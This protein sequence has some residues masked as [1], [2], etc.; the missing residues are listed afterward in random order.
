MKKF[1]EKEL[2]QLYKEAK[3]KEIPDLWK[4]IEEN[5]ASKAPETEAAPVKEKQGSHRRWLTGLAAAAAVALLAI[6]AWQMQQG[7]RKDLNESAQEAPAAEAN[8]AMPPADSSMEAEGG[9]FD[10]ALAE[11]EA[12]QAWEDEFH[13]EVDLKVEQVQSTL[14]GFLVTGE[15]LAAEENWFEAGEQ[16]RVFYE[17]DDYKEEDFFGTIRVLLDVEEEN[18]LILEILP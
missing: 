7:G 17:G 11:E 8:E 9:S 14:E 3:M 1:S 5:L 16:V 15:I 6:P 18:L 13:L 2:M 12:G 4:G 10:K